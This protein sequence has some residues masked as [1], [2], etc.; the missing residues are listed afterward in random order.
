MIPDEGSARTGNTSATV[1]N[2][3]YYVNDIELIYLFMSMFKLYYFSGFFFTA[4]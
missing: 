2:K 1:E 3:Q 4:A